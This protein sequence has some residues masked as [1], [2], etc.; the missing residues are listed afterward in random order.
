M[1]GN[2]CKLIKNTRRSL[3]NLLT[4]IYLLYY[5]ITKILHMSFFVRF[6]VKKACGNPTLLPSEQLPAEDSMS[7]ATTTLTR[8]TAHSMAGNKWVSPPNT[9]M[10]RFLVEINKS[11]D[12]YSKIVDR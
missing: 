11:K 10:L 4:L 5:T 8:T 3:F 2:I 1:I 12:F 9:E 7:A 6:Q